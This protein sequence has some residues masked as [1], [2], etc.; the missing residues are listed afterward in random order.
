MPTVMLPTQ[1]SAITITGGQGAISNRLASVTDPLA[2]TEITSPYT[3][4][5]LVNANANGTLNI[6]L[7]S[8]ITALTLNSVSLSI[9]GGIASN[10]E[11]VAG[12]LFLKQGMILVQG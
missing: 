9:S 2:L 3:C 4:P 1:V 10:V 11:P 7:P 12:S 5:R 6:R 8:K